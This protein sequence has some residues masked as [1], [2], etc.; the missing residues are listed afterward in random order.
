[1]SLFRCPVCGAPLERGERAY[2]CLGR[3]SYDLAK[4]GY[5]YLLPPTRSTPPPPAMTARWPRPG[6]NF[7]PA[8]IMSHC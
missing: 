8:G 7:Y 4:E 5:A 3:H 1:M 2:T 6:G